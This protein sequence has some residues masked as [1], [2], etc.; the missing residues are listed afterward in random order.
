MIENMR[1]YT[2]LMV[3]VLVLLAAGLILT[4][5]NFNA[6]SGGRAKVTE[7][8]GEGI[9]QIQYRKMGFNSLNVIKQ[10]RDPGL[11]AYAMDMIFN[12]RLDWRMMMGFYQTG[13][14]SEEVQK[15]VTRR[16]VIAK[17]AAEYG[18]YPSTAQAKKHIKEQIFAQGGNFNAESY[19]NFMKEI[20]SSGLQEEDFVNLVA[21]SLV[22]DRLKNLVSSGLQTPNRLTDR[23]IKFQQQTL[24]LTTV[25][26]D[27]DRYKKE[28]K[29]TEEEIED[30]WKENDFKYLTDR[31]IRIS[32][33]VEMPV[34]ATPRP[35]A[36]VRAAEAKDEEFK[37]LDDAFQKELAKWE[38][39]VEKP[40]DKL[41]AQTLYDLSYKVDDTEGE[42]FT[43]EVASAKLK[44]T[45]T[46]LF[47]AKNVA[48]ELKLLDTKDGVS[49]ADLI[50]QIKISESL[51]Y[52]IPAPIKLAGNGW[53]YVRYDE[54][55][56]PVT[57]SYEEAKELAKT[58]YIQENAHTA[59]LAD[60]QNIKDKLA[61]SITGGA[62]AEEAAQINNLKAN[63]RTGMRYDNLGKDERGGVVGSEYEIFENGTITD[64]K[65]FSEKNVE[66]KNQVT[67]VYLN[68]REVVNTAEV[69]DTRLRIQKA[70]SEMLQDSVFRAWMNE[71]VTEA[72]IPVMDFN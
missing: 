64:N 46:E 33:L 4:M 63:I 15:F 52:R 12:Q 49:I 42:N 5:G 11:T 41:S 2:G 47:S 9:D 25:A 22:Y 50:F 44:L 40:A 31:Q 17:T 30:Y 38:L 7:V 58:D 20:G 67:L 18:I 70:R 1:K 57:K 29:P 51:K 3:V 35:V 68:K 61:K 56:M 72:N 59:M 10:L 21:E 19:Q 24:D 37:K 65:S 62:S 60:V 27:I 69:V 13:S 48:D 66:E 39:E 28:L 71:A 36:P 16:I 34:Y 45:S 8:Y 54:E 14:N 43:A 6:N 32:Y 53:F 55:V 23:S 26:I